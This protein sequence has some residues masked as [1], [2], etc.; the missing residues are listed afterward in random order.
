MKKLL[1]LCL[2]V[3]LVL[4]MVPVIGAAAEGTLTFSAGEAKGYAGD[5]VVVPVS[6]SNNPGII[7]TQVWITYD[8]TVFELVACEDTQLGGIAFPIQNPTTQKPYRIS[9]GNGLATENYTVNGV[10]ANLKFRIK[11]TA[12]AGTYT[13]TLEVDG[14]SVFDANLDGVSFEKANGAIVVE[15]KHANTT[16]VG[17]QDATCKAEGYTGDVKCLDCT[18][19]I[20]SGSATE[21]LE[22]VEVVEGK[23]PADC[24]NAGSTGTTKCKVCGDVLKEATVID[25]LDH[26]FVLEGQKDATCEAPGYTGDE[27]CS[28]CEAEGEKGTEISQLTHN[29]VK[30][31][32]KDAT[33]AEAG[34]EAHYACDAGCGQVAT[35]AE[36][37]EIV[38]AEDL[39]IEKVAHKI[40]K[41]DGV[42]A[43]EEK[44]GVKEH[45]ECSA[46]KALF[47]DA[48]GKTEI[49]KEDVVIAKLG[50][51]EEPKTEE[52]KVED[53]NADTSD[54]APA[55]NDVAN[56]VVLVTMLMAIA[57]AA[58]VV[59]KKKA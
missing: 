44:E 9:W 59:L 22:H 54:K 56:I 29:W 57:A 55:T 53:N 5:E 27:K 41:V 15:C 33:C 39:A 26:D 47:S 30:K 34:M 16:L 11:D 24:L 4:A 23:V 20:K 40:S 12:A 38:K 13:L 28:R 8:S 36:G 14:G 52:P 32:K 10:F 31:D 42:A 1:A 2:T 17:K 50:K 6:M 25:A 49:K 43:T 45:Y 58:V 37:K 21:M 48:E 19:I 18:E 35:D 3:M 51:V 46:C 7:M